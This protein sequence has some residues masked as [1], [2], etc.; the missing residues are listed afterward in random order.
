ML[1]PDR[2]V[3]LDAIPSMVGALGHR[4]PDQWGYWTDPAQSVSLLNARLAIVDPAAGRQ[5]IANEDGT[6]WVTFNG[7]LYGFERLAADLARLGHRFRTRTDTEVLVHLYEEHGLGLTRF[8]RGEFALALHDARTHTTILIRDRLGVKPLFYAVLPDRLVFASEMKGLFAHPDVEPRLDREQVV[9]MLGAVFLPGRALFE[10]VRQV[11][12]GTCVVVREGQTDVRRYWSLD[13]TPSDPRRAGADDQPVV[14]EFAHRFEEAVRIRLHGDVE[15]GVYLSG[16]VDSAAVARVV[17]DVRP[18]LKAFTVGFA[19][20][21]Y[22]ETDRAAAV[23]SALGIE[24]HVMRLGPGDLA[25]PFVDAIWFGEAPVVNAHAAAK[26]E[27]SRLA[28]QS[29]KAVVTGEGADEVL[30]G[31]AQFR[32]QR[33]LDTL[34]RL[35]GDKA[36]RLAMRR[37][38]ASAGALTGTIP[39]TEYPDYARVTALFGCYP[40]PL[41]K[42]PY[43]QRRLGPL[44]SGPLRRRARA[45]DSLAEL[46]PLLDRA[47]LEGLPAVAA[48]QYVLL[49]TELPAYIL[50]SLGDRVEMAHGIEGRTPF[51]DHELVEFLNRLPADFKLRGDTDKWVLREAMRERLPGAVLATKRAF[52]APSL[53]TLGLDRRRSPL[54]EYFRADLVE[55]AGVF[56]PAAIAAMRLAARLLPAGTRA[57]AVAEAA[58]VL[59]LS[60]HVLFDLYCRRLRASLERYRRPGTL[61]LADGEV[62]AA[63]F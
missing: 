37:L 2:R 38:L 33:L 41:A 35:P 39:I 52:M 34:R 17:T 43:Y 10:G 31:Y 11:E 29:V 3:R 49:R 1:V 55:D 16:G 56:N 19:D 20:A 44:L 4:G 40:Y 9:H 5:P 59:A 13:L 46:A 25:E 48:S 6:V 53:T 8:L 7:E 23:A 63:V 57:Q 54:D 15:T 18:S 21:G 36:A 22:D 28:A 30:L 58:T 45:L 32:H 60:V 24:H 61:A 50:G 51:L 47:A 14:E 26:F 27:L 62:T 42:T 12:P